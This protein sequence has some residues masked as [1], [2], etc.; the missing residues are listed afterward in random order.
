M[1]NRWQ[2]KTLIR[3][4]NMKKSF[5]PCLKNMEYSRRANDKKSFISEKQIKLYSTY[6]LKFDSTLSIM[7]IQ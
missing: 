5:S 1:I 7:V 2:I 3:K 4:G 6:Y